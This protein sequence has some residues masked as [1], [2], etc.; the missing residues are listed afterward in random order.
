MG[1]VQHVC[2]PET[3]H[4]TISS[5]ANGTPAPLEAEFHIPGAKQ[6]HIDMTQVRPTHTYL[7]NY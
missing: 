2:F 6:A 5:V 3:G 4:F 1:A 7:A